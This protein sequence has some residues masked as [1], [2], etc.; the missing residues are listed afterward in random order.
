MCVCAS[1]WRYQLCLASYN[2]QLPTQKGFIPL[3]IS[4][5]EPVVDPETGKP[6][7]Q[8]TGSLSHR[9]IYVVDADAQG[10]WAGQCG[11]VAVNARPWYSTLQMHASIRLSFLP[12]FLP[13]ARHSSIHV[14]IHTLGL[15]PVRC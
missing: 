8:A 7:G 15:E 2:L 9:Y 12:S 6:T 4:V 1:V 11:F 14:M 10:A 13:P 5:M 3:C